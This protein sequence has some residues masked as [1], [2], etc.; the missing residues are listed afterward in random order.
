MKQRFEEKKAIRRGTDA[1]RD[2]VRDRNL[3]KYK[4]H[5]NVPGPARLAVERADNSGAVNADPMFMADRQRPGLPVK[6]RPN[7]Q[8]SIQWA[9]P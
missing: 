8:R 9:F 4:P 7:R 6:L 1:N 2:Q 5:A 3:K